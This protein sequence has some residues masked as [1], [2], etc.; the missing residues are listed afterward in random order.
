MR[1]YDFT[2]VMRR[3]YPV[4]FSKAKKKHPGKMHKTVGA[5]GRYDEGFVSGGRATPGFSYRGR[6]LNEGC[7][8]TFET[9]LVNKGVMPKV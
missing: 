2:V 8:G 4:K 1:R 9:W 7:P 6:W 5:V 3:G